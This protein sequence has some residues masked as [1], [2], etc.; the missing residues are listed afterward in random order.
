M[1]AFENFNNIGVT[2]AAGH[3]GIKI[4]RMQSFGPCPA[5]KATK[6]GS[7]DVRLPIGITPNGNGWHCH[8]CKASG[9]AS[10]LLAY[11]LVGE[12]YKT[13]SS[14]NQNIIKQWL[15]DHGYGDKKYNNNLSNISK[16][17]GTKKQE[18]KTQQYVHPLFKWGDDLPEKYKQTLHSQKGGKVLHYLLNVR[19]L[20]K[21][22]IE[23]ADLGCL[24]EN[25]GQQKN[26]W[27]V[28]PLKDKYGKTVNMRFRSIPPQPKT[29]RVCPNRPMPLYGSHTLGSK[30]DFVIITEGELDVLAMNSYGY[31]GVVS[32][33]TGAAANWKEDWLNI[34]EPYKGFYIWYDNDKA[35][36]DGANKLAEKLGKYRCFRVRSKEKD[37]GEIL[38]AQGTSDYISKVFDQVE[39]YVENN[40]NKVDS[41][42]EE[43]EQLIKN[44][45]V[46]RGM[47]TG[48]ERLDK[49][50]GG[51]RPGLWVITGDTGHGKT[52]WATWL[53]YE[54]ALRHVPVMVTS[55]E[56]RPIG[57]V[58]KLLRAEVGGDFM[59]MTEVE[60]NKGLNSLGKLPIY[61]L[62]HYG[63]LSSEKVIET[64]RFSKRRYGIKI[65]LV[66]HLGFLTATEQGENERIVIQNIVRKLATIAV[67]ESITIMLIC[68][69][70][71][72]SVAQQRRVMISDLKGASAIRQDAH[73]ALV[74]QRQDMTQERGFPA[75]T[76]WVDKVR[77]EFGLNNSH[78]TMAFDP[79]SCVY[80]DTWDETPSAS[81][82]LKIILPDE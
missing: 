67:N 72:M 21:E 71:N 62:D 79:I 82:G 80:A 56:Q 28:I 11:H 65:A 81:K 14:T 43:L 66:D 25:N 41:Y 26:Y 32:G 6:R 4:G 59:D 73:V 77:S 3:I 20:D 9:S 47:T 27:L 63:E 29:F 45:H 60:R 68:H 44:P 35:G 52:T 33:T 31:Q 7:G 49:V 2:K 61:I 55:F 18:S 69:P 76:V 57:T 13:S 46:L 42:S 8:V 51:I 30:D 58:Q 64:I 74:I 5:C 34:L 17:T 15:I 1:S 16:Y 78:C 39:E 50:L 53:L 36:N 38:Q 37:V 22:V 10:D 70:N 40:L 48:S 75:T 12:K 54:Q 19:G 23:E 24:I